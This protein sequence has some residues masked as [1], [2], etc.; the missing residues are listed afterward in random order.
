[1]FA[2]CMLEESIEIQ[3]IEVTKF[4]INCS[5]QTSLDFSLFLKSKKRTWKI[6]K[7][8]ANLT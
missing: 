4:T 5:W 1:M 8:S 6:H 7:T 2:P 3:S